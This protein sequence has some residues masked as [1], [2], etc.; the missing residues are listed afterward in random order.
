LAGAAGLLEV[1]AFA[2]IALGW[3]ISSS[4]SA[5]MA[6]SS[7]S[8]SVNRGQLP[9]A[10]PLP[11]AASQSVWLAAHIWL[12]FAQHLVDVFHTLPLLPNLK[13]KIRASTQTRL[14]ILRE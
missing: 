9:A 14:A 6:L 11:V 2:A 4:T 1:A 10:F 7:S 8:F 5:R 3:T 12:A 13:W